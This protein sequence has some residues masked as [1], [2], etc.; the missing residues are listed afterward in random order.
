MINFLVLARLRRDLWRAPHLRTSKLRGTV[1]H[2][3]QRYRC[4][5]EGECAGEMSLLDHLFLLLMKFTFAFL[6][7]QNVYVMLMHDSRPALVR[8]LWRALGYSPLT[9]DRLAILGTCN[10]FGPS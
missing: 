7:F 8:L 9:T 10:L 5:W 4:A 6:V 2:A 1:P 3:V